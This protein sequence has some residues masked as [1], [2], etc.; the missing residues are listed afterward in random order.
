MAER[1]FVLLPLADLAPDWRH[2]STGERI[3]SLIARLPRDQVT[4]PLQESP[5]AGP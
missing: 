2:P 4:R 5:G 3:S 1:A